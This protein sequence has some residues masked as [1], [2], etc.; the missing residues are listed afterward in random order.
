MKKVSF[1]SVF[2]ISLALATSSTAF[3]QPNSKFIKPV[4]RGP[5]S[6]ESVYFIMTDR[7]ENGDTSNDY[8]GSNKSRSVSGFAPDDIGWWHGGDFKGITKRL[9]YIKAMGFTSIWI[10]PP[11]VQKYVQGD[12]AAYHGY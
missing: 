7:F 5:Q 1:F 12:S 9:D 4:V 8:G 3:A 2:V 10:T 6:D 11:V